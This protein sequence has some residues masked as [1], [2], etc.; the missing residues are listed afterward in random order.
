MRRK[1]RGSLNGEKG[2]SWQMVRSSKYKS[3]LQDLEAWKTCGER[4]SNKQ[5][6]YLVSQSLKV[7]L[8]T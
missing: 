3:G 8:R 2:L 6:E 5:I 1:N 7:E 4:S